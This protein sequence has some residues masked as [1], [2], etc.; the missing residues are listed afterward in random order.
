MRDD[1]YRSKVI[2]RD[3][4]GTRLNVA[5]PKL[6][7]GDS[8]VD[9]ENVLYERKDKVVRITLNRPEKLNALNTALVEDLD[10]ALKR[11]EQDEEAKV[12]ILKGAG[13]A[14][15]TGMDLSPGEGYL[16]E[17]EYSRTVRARREKMIWRVQKVLTIWD[18]RLPVIAQIH[19]Y[20]LA[21]GCYIA[22]VSDISIASEDTQFGHPGVRFGGGGEAFPMFAWLLGPQRAKELLFT[23]KMID[24]KEA[25]RI[26]LI[27]RAVPKDKLDEEVNELAQEIANVRGDAVH[28]T[29]VAVNTIQEIMGLRVAFAYGNELNTLGRFIG[30]YD[31]F[32]EEIHEKGVKGGFAW[33]DSGLGGSK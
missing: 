1:R 28:M 16:E 2:C 22:M 30:T 15:C 21:V 5:E 6:K 31:E 19:G 13:R 25:D 8:R 26:G 12:V 4:K 27:N 11:A 33:R 24:A 20:C 14:F 32:A 10:N 23:G 3:E 29:K 17:S 7:E 18:L 9:Y